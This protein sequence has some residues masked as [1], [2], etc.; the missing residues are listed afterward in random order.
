MAEDHGA[1]EAGQ[2]PMACTRGRKK[3]ERIP[4]KRAAQRV[5]SWK[6][7]N[8]T[9]GFLGPVSTGAAGRILDS[10]NPREV[11]A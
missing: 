6:V 2:L 10:A 3:R 7:Q 11:K 8:E 5:R 4:K 9:R 1:P